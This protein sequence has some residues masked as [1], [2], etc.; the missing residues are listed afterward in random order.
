MKREIAERERTSS[1]FSML[2]YQESK[3]THSG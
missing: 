1:R 2:A 3:R